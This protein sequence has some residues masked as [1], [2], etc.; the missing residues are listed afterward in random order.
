METDIN[1]FY[2]LCTLYDMRCNYDRIN[3]T[4]EA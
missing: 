4:Q 1:K 3:F 2:F